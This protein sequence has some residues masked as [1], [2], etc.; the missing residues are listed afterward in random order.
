MLRR[1][2][3]AAEHPIFCS[4][5]ICEISFGSIERPATRKNSWDKAKTV[6]RLFR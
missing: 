1:N 3:R 5:A 4:K 6:C 2:K